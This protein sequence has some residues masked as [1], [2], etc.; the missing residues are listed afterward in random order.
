MAEKTHT[1][2]FKMKD[3]DDILRDLKSNKARDP[4]GIKRII[5]KSTIIG[6]NLKKS[7]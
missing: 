5:F 2:P 4:E 1:K 3:L 7:L 6:S